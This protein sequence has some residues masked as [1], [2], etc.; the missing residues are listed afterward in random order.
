MKPLQM[1]F[2][3]GVLVLYSSLT[4]SQ[5]TIKGNLTDANTDEAI[6]GASIAVPGT[7]YG[8]IS[9]LNGS[10]SFS[11]PAG[12]YEIAISFTGY[13]MLTKS[14]EV[15]DGQETNLG[16]IKMHST[17]I[18]LD[19]VNIIS[20]I[21]ID[22]LTPVAVSSVKKKQIE[23]ELGDRDLPLILNTTPG[24]YAT[25]GGG[26]FGD[27]DIRVR[28]FD[29]RNIAVLV[30]GVPVNDMEN[31]W[32]YWS[33]W[34]G[35]GDATLTIQSQRGLGASRLA[36]NS[37][38]GTINI[39]TKTTDAEKGGSIN[40]QVTDYG[41]QKTILSLSTG[42]LKNGTA[43]Y[44]V[45][46]RTWG[47][48]YI[49]G[50]FVN[51]WSYYLSISQDI[52]EKHRLAFTAIG[53]PQTH[54]Q[55]DSW[56]S[57]SEYDKYGIKYNKDW[58]YKYGQMLNQRINQY[59]KPQFAL[60]WYYTINKKTF[61]ATSAYV[62]IGNG[63]GS[64]PLG[65]NT[66]LT[67]VG[68]IDW[69]EVVA[70]NS[71]NKGIDTTIVQGQD[72]LSQSQSIL[73]NS[74]NNHFWYGII[75]TL[76][77]KLNDNFNFM[78]GLDARHYKGEHY[79]EVR[80]L[81]GGDY[82]FE[83]Y[84]YAVDGVSGRNQIMKVGDKIAY[85]ND[86]LLTYG[87]LF[88]QLEYA[89][90]NLSAF[91][92]GSASNT[93]YQRIDRYNY[94]S[95][96]KSETKSQIGYNV[97]AGANYNLNEYHN[98][99]ANVGHYSKAP[100]FDFLFPNFNNVL[101]TDD[102]VNE[103]VFGTEIGYGLK[104]RNI[105]LNLNGYYTKWYDKSLL[106]GSYQQDGR[107][108]RSFI[109]GLEA[110]HTGIEFDGQINIT[111]TLGLGLI[112]GYGEW[113]WHND[114]FALNT[115]DKT[116]DTTITEVYADGLY[117]GG[118]PQTQMGARLNYNPFGGKINLTMEVINYSRFYANFDPEGR[119]NPNDHSQPY[120]VPSYS[121]ANFYAGYN[122]KVSNHKAWFGVNIYN[123][124][125][126]KHWLVVNDGSTHTEKDASGY[127]GFGRTFNM[128]LKFYF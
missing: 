24:V 101:S 57:K 100:D 74:I 44:F 48:G 62:S 81:M 91:V 56:I 73:R 66:N 29:Q 106:T 39:I 40:Y 50:T 14:I 68:Q 9:G 118:Q 13:E 76:N 34:S 102:F 69:D 97:K 20:S 124:F 80:D 4:F 1:L 111:N 17:S 104:T 7:M 107:E 47:K 12:V 89:S 110:T 75:S 85:D 103:K 61:L 72:T 108:I 71:D 28:G 126:T 65:K 10:F 99:Y 11:V 78:A 79:R 113:K 3:T 21:A 46:S 95:D 25:Q 16:Q 42:K 116:G 33:N 35:L 30:N 31:G 92:S 121:L 128:S 64:G 94:V 67:P 37:I 18:G 127:Y 125:D 86:G 19:E 77:Y 115:D 109:K 43:V 58:G 98:V 60:N 112:V 2:I 59:H 83:S 96:Q 55:R 15:K 120:K 32:V 27:G 90:G 23:Q 122:F 93:Y 6:F 38:G 88:A 54:G 52:N 53:A 119:E 36:I 26:G 45:G 84:K 22:R 63:Y 5:G 105:R 49:D 70:W 117:V 8:N 114:V 82:Y 123:M 51:A 41:N 87:G